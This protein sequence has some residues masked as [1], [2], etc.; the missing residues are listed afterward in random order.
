MV[1]DTALTVS[2]FTTAFT[3]QTSWSVTGYLVNPIYDSNP[4]SGTPVAFP[5][6]SV[7]VTSNSGSNGVVWGLA[8]LVTQQNS[9]S[10]NTTSGVL[11]AYDATT[12]NRVWT[13]GL[14]SSGCA[15]GCFSLFNPD[16]YAMGCVK[17]ATFS[18]PTVVNGAAYVP[19]FSLTSGTYANHTGIV[20][21]CGHGSLACPSR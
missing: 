3:G 14:P 17:G 1:T 8:T 6:G 9:G 16:T 7:T 13:S 10:C 20:V 11:D 5:G 15:G 21:F 4:S 18:L 2:G 12:L 19:T